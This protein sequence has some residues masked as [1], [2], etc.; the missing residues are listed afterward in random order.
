MPESSFWRTVVQILRFVRSSSV[1]LHTSARVFCAHARGLLPREERYGVGRRRA[2][3]YSAAVSFCVGSVML[4]G[5]LHADHMRRMRTI[6]FVS[7][8]A[9]LLAC[10]LDPVGSGAPGP[11]DAGTPGD[12]AR[13]GV[14][15]PDGATADGQPGEDGANHG[16]PD[17]AVVD[18]A[19]AAP[20]TSNDASPVEAAVPCAGNTTSCGA[21]GACVDCTGNPSG[22]ACVSGTC[23]CTSPGDCPVGQA[24]SSK[25]HACG[26]SCAGGLVCN[27]G[28]CDGTT[29]QAGTADYAC[30]S[31]GRSCV[32]CSWSNGNPVCING[33]ACG[34]PNGDCQG[35]GG[36]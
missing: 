5:G 21:V 2:A 22:S 4:D 9:G 18:D 25:N 23:G 3:L 20:D 13:V 17:G 19:Q 15:T 8:S 32:A 30:G 16:P 34:C 29:C 12:D 1:G 31:D 28:C 35:G 36:S 11:D 24:C 33:S 14:V 26:A 10:G 27:G 6:A 7:L